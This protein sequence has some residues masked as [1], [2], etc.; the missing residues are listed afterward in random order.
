MTSQR[1][2]EGRRARAERGLYNGGRPPLGYDP[3][4]DR[5]G[6][7]VVNEAEARVVRQAFDLY[8]E[9][10]NDRLV[11]D[12]LNAKGYRT[13]KRTAKRSGKTSGGGR[14]KQTTVAQMLRNPTYIGQC[15]INRKKRGANQDELPEDRRYRVVPG[16]WKPILSAEQ[17]ERV[18]EL[19]QRNYKAKRSVATKTRQTHLLKGLVICDECGTLLEP[20]SGTGSDGL[21][22]YYYRHSRRAPKDCAL[23]WR[24]LPSEEVEKLILGRLSHLASNIEVVE[25]VV[26]IATASLKA[27]I[28]DVLGRL[29]ERQRRL[30]TLKQD[31]D[32]LLTLTTALPEGQRR[33]FLEPKLAAIK[34]QMEEVEAEISLLERSKDEL[35]GNAVDAVDLQHALQTFD[36]LFAELEPHEQQELLGY[37][38][39]EIRIDRSCV[40]IRLFGKTSA[41]LMAVQRDGAN[42]VRFA[43]IS[44]KLLGLDSNRF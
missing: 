39:N 32:G 38:I 10:G 14:F 42:R 30:A 9:L 2:R 19:R 17:F 18:Q 8:E 4:P 33:A 6:Y 1:T 15:E 24:S 20:G 37:L 13:K 44:A 35:Q 3:D 5:K 7:L 23:P 16:R 21:R 41:D 22:R 12:A 40:T 31:A 28:P 29:R 27:E 43:P 36:A 34:G 25:E 26:A 11:M